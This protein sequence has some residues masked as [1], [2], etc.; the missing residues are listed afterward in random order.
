MQTSY[1]AIAIQQLG[2]QYEKNREAIKTIS[3]RLIEGVPQER[4][5]F[6][7]GS[8]HS[9]IFA[10]ELYHRAGG[11]SFLIPVVEETTLPI[12]GPARARAAERTPDALLGALHR[13]NPRKSE[14]L[15]INSQSGIN[16][17]IVELALEAKRMGM[18]TVAFTSVAHSSAA[19]SRHTSGKRLFEVC[20]HIVDL[21]GVSGD[22]LVPVE[23][24]PRAVSVGPLSTLSAVFLAHIILSEVSVELERRGIACVYT[25]V[26]TPDGEA[27]NR[28]IEEKASRRDPRLTAL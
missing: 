1:A 26:N 27:R 11:P 12:F 19:K 21:G 3:Q 5:L 15:W 9:A 10:M 2:L 28:E 17:A 22:A 23:G 4:A 13:A 24:A 8:G 7:A 14:M 25:S 16:P 20:D 18:E 6:A